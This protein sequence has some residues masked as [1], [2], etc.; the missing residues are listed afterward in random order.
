V[1]AEQLL[2]VEGLD[3]DLAFRLMDAVHA[4]FGE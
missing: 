3:Q 2:Q 4:H 1:T